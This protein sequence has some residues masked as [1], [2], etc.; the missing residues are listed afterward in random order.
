MSGNKMQRT[1]GHK[2]EKVIGGLRKLGNKE[3]RHVHPSSN[4]ITMIK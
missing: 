4:I 3:L 1:V 2:R